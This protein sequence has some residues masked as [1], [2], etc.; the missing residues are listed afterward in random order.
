MA[1]ISRLTLEDHTG[2]EQQ[3]SQKDEWFK[4][5]HLNIAA[6]SKQER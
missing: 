5:S 4:Y 6:N 3:L 2:K 1:Q